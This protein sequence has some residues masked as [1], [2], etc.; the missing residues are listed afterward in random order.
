MHMRLLAELALSFL[1]FSFPFLDNPT[2]SV[3]LRREYLSVE[4]VEPLFWVLTSRS[5][6]KPHRGA[7]KDRPKEEGSV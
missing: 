4:D 2:W 6:A 3:T 5:E 7:L 1:F